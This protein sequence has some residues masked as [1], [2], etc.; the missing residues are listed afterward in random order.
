MGSRPRPDGRLTGTNWPF[1]LVAVAG[2]VGFVLP[3]DAFQQATLLA[4]VQ[5]I[6]TAADPVV[7][8]ALGVG[9]LSV[10]LRGGAADVSG[11]VLFLLPMT[12]GIVVTA[13]S[14]PRRARPPALVSSSSSPP[15]PGQPAD[16]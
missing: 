15:S 14:S 2:P 10:R 16:G 11:E 1:Y 4:P 5:A 7:S 13:G 9:W 3:R 6:V 12:A 8:I